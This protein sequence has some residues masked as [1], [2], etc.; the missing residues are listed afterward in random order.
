MLCSSG[1]GFDPYVD[2]QRLFFGMDGSWRGTATMYDYS[3][4]S[5]WLQVTGTCIDGRRSGTILEPL[6][7]VYLTTW[8]AWRTLHPDTQV[9]DRRAANLRAGQEYFTR[10]GS[11]SGAPFVP[12]ELISSM[13]TDDR[14]LE[15]FSLL[16]GVRIGE[17]ARAYPF[18]ALR[19]TPV[20]EE[21]IGDRD[22]TVWFDEA[23]RSAIAFS[24]SVGDRTLSFKFV[25][26]GALEDRETRSRWTLDGRCVSGA[27]KGAALEPVYGFMSEG[28]GRLALHPKTTIWG[29]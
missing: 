3:T 2:D 15:P 13:Q 17:A 16:Y 21:R 4:E 11:K 7:R 24:R 19:T 23:S 25:G 5:L 14:R 28:Y 12:P 27:F 10:S 18:A 29:P 20:V 1:V 26:A 9:M 22:V 6:T 8:R